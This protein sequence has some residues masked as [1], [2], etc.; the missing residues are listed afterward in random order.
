MIVYTPH[1]LNE[2]NTETQRLLLLLLFMSENPD[3]CWFARNHASGSEIGG[4]GLVAGISLPTGHIGYYV[5]PMFRDVVF[6]LP[7]KE[8]VNAPIVHDRVS[9]T[10][11]DPT[12]E[13]RF[14]ALMFNHLIETRVLPAVQGDQDENILPPEVMGE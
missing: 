7:V 8:Y 14:A 1:N 4:G 9:E 2:Y 11:D 3:M 5:P 10:A 12:S 6:S 13:T